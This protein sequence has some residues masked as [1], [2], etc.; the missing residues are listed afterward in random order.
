MQADHLVCTF[1]STPSNTMSLLSTTAWF[2]AA[3]STN[4]GNLSARAALFAWFRGERSTLLGRSS[5]LLAVHKPVATALP[6]NQGNVATIG[7]VSE[8]EREQAALQTLLRGLCV[9]LPYS[10]GNS[11]K[12]CISPANRSNPNESNDFT[13]HFADN[14]SIPQFYS[15]LRLP[16]LHI[17]K[18]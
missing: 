7:V 16:G 13:C 12:G 5:N 1:G 14:K 4:P 9:R 11:S 6:S 3:T 17:P 8:R 18:K 15:S 10:Q 2:E